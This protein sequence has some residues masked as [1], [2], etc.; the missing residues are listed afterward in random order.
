MHVI[1]RNRKR[2]RGELDGEHEPP[3]TVQEGG[4]SCKAFRVDC[5]GPISF[6]YSPDKPLSCGARL[7]AETTNPI[8]IHKEAKL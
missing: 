6:I 3:I 5:E 1:R 8:K 2:D 4:K 7:W